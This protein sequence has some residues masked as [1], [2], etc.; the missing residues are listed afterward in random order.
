VRLRGPDIARTRRRGGWRTGT[1]SRH[2][3]LVRSH[4]DVFIVVAL[5]KKKKG[6]CRKEGVRRLFRGD[7]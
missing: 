2:E 1:A 4:L 6:S 7:Y 5:L 3:C